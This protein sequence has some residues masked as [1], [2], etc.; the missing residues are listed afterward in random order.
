MIAD[1]GRFDAYAKA[2]A[3][4]V[5]QGDVVAEIGCGPGGFTLLACQAG[6][7]RVFAIELDDSIHLARELA[8]ANGFRDRM[9]FFQGD[10]RRTELPERANVIVA[11]IRGALP[12]GGEALAAMKDAR[13]RL[14]APGGIILPPS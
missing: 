6:A 1:A 11:D 13:D 10:S 14:L 3:A 9:E 4:T 5:G 8:A 12:V 2:I 7:R